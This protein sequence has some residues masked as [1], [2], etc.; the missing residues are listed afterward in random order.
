MLNKEQLVQALDKIAEWSL[1][2][3]I[4]T[5][6]FSKS[7][8]EIMIVIGI[9]ALVLKKVMCGEPL[10]RNSSVNI[11]LIIFLIV[12]LPSFFNTEYM[13]LSLRALFSKT[14]KFAALFL[15]AQ[16]ALD[17]KEKLENFSIMMLVSC[18]IILI[19][20]YIQYYVTHIDILHQYPSFQYCQASMLGFATAMSPYKTTFLGFPTASFPFPNDFA[21]WILIMIFPAA[22]FTLLWAKGVWK[23]AGIGA[24][25][26]G[27][28][29]FLMATR[30]RGA[31]L[32][33][34]VSLLVVPFLGFRNIKKGLAL[35]LVLVAL[36][37][38]LLLKKDVRASIGSFASVSDR[39]TMWNNAWKIFK[40]HPVIGNGIN[41]FFVNY[42]NVRDDE[43]K[44]KKGS[45]AHNCYFQMA[46]DIGIVGLLGFLAF[47][48]F[49]IFRGMSSA[50]RTEDAFLRSLQV[51]LV[52]G[53]IA[54][55]IQSIFDTNLYSLNL[56]ALF[57]ISAG[58]LAA[59]GNISCE[60]PK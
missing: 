37:S 14:L 8:V 50:I 59:A 28:L 53:I 56:A 55:L 7:F 48:A 33:F 32:G 20:A 19:D 3:L 49:L 22:A 54:Y 15:V 4:F 52:L 51:G 60:R 34:L 30:T 17:K 25:F 13:S 58:V 44:G 31:W 26:A 16:G 2:I 18:V 9:V 41:T 10:I 5:L 38:P 40:Q 57:W 27:L 46:A 35:L 47:I 1:Y 42:M 24:I 6:P 23:R 39:G 43:Y 36:M 29:F 21:A 11:A 45:Y 12:S